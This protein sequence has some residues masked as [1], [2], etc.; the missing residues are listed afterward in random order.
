MFPPIFRQ[1]CETPMGTNLTALCVINQCPSDATFLSMIAT[2]C[3]NLS[4]LELGIP[5]R[6]LHI[7]QLAP[8]GSLPLR[9]LRLTRSYSLGTEPLQALGKTWPSLESFSHPLAR[10]ELLELPM[11]LVHLPCLKRLW[12]SAPDQFPPEVIE[13]ANSYR[14]PR[15]EHLEVWRS[16][17]LILVVNFSWASRVI[18][19]EVDV[20][21]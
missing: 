4:E 3:P 21:A 9:I 5:A 10:I 2:K 1:L 16:S 17:L 15:Q 7:S 11:A 19:S 8:L 13:L 6:D 20:L 14:P 12:L 18:K